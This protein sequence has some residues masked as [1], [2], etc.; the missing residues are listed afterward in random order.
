MLYF[1]TLF[2][3]FFSI[4]LLQF[5]LAILLLSAS[6]WRHEQQ[7]HLHNCVLLS[8]HK[9]ETSTICTTNTLK[10]QHFSVSLPSQKVHVQASDKVM[11]KGF[12]APTFCGGGRKSIFW[13]K[14]WLIL[15]TFI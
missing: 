14:E 9:Y 11:A 12:A 2:F 8:H 10:R 3:T 7:S 6:D 4:I 1:I 5:I 13:C 15:T